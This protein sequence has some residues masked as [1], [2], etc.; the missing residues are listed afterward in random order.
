MY[1]FFFLFHSVFAATDPCAETAKKLC[2]TDAE[3][4]VRWAC[5]APKWET[6]SKECQTSLKEETKPRGACY[7]A[8]L[9]YCNGIDLRKSYVCLMERKSE[10]PE[11]CQEQLTQMRSQGHKFRDRIREACASDSKNFCPRLIDA[12]LTDCLADNYKKRL[13]SDSCQK[14]IDESVKKK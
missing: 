1:L 7:L 8:S 4:D 11:L 5:L 10:L 3:K 2:P 14:A 12:K 13:L 9:V 6:L